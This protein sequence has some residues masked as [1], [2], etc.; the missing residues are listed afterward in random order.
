MRA[1]QVLTG[2]LSCLLAL[3]AAA[4]TII[5]GQ[6]E[7]AVGRQPV[8]GVRIEAELAGK[9]KTLPPTNA[10]GRFSLDL[11]AVF[12][13]NVRKASS[14][15]L[16]FSHDG[17]QEQNRVL[18]FAERGRPQAVTIEVKLAPV[19][20]IGV[21]SGDE[22]SK[23]ASFRSSTGH[24]LFM[25]PYEVDTSGRS[26]DA[27]RLTREFNRVLHRA[28]VTRIQ[29]LPVP[30]PPGDI[31]LVTLPVQ[32]DSGNLEL[33]DAYGRFLNA[34]GM[35]SGSIESDAPQGMLVSSQFRIVPESPG[36]S[37]R[38]LFVDD[39]LPQTPVLSFTQLHNKLQRLWADATLLAIGLREFEEARGRKDRIGLQRIRTY[40]T[41]QLAD[42]GPGAD[43]LAP[44]IRAL[45]DQVVR[46]L[47]R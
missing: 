11:D 23:V 3:Q 43:E 1:L 39:L 24:A 12:G 32:A 2:T 10:Q 35:I 38:T 21:L 14:L 5:G 47:G 18:P 9:V 30:D 28:I 33:I 36:V 37:G 31:S 19:A 4:A 45:R 44:Q 13:A 25:L 27:D 6:V 15:A 16:S 29:S 17:F 42:M 40:L 41:A 34:L 46:E 20:G 26:A 7:D 8:S 22:Q